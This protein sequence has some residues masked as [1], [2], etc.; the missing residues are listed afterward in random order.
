MEVI[1]KIENVICVKYLVEYVM[2][3]IENTVKK[4]SD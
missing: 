4:E 1:Y 3:S 2:I